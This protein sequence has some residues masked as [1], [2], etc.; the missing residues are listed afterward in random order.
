VLINLLRN[1][2]ESMQESGITTGKII[3]TTSR[4]SRA[5]DMAEVSV[6]DCGK[7][8]ADTSTL[9]TI[10]Q[11]FYTTKPSG[12]GMGLAISRALIEAHG[13]KMWA[14]QNVGMGISVHFTLPFVI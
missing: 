3:I 8:V 5:P 11:P 7:G 1:G 6:S 12:L 4:F 9:K 2:L 14:E 10:F 13:G